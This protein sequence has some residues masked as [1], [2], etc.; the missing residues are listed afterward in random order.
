[1][2]LIYTPGLSTASE[3]SSLA[4]RGVGM[5]VVRNDVVALGGRIETQ[6]R[7]GQGTGFKLVLPLTT[8]VTQVVMLRAG[9]LTIGVPSTQVELVRRVSADELGQ[10][11]TKKTLTVGGEEVPFYWAGALCSRRRSRRKRRLAHCQW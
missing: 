2:Q 11:Y 9:A 8:A 3:V 10:A 5:D 4:G 6:S 7:A 1:M